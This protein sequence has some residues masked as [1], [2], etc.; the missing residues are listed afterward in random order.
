M[1]SVRSIVKLDRGAVGQTAILVGGF[2]ERRPFRDEPARPL[3][4]RASPLTASPARLGAPRSLRGQAACT[5]SRWPVP[6]TRA[7]T[8]REISDAEP[9]L[10]RIDPELSRGRGAAGA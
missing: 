6:P 2:A 4:A 10:T 8:P 3:V 5:V 9:P 1:A 7:N